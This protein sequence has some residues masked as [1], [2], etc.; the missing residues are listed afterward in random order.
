MAWLTEQLS[1]VRNRAKTPIPSRILSS[2]F[3]TVIDR[4]AAVCSTAPSGSVG[5]MSLPL[6]LH[7]SLL[8]HLTLSRRFFFELHV[9]QQLQ[10]RTMGNE[11]SPS[12]TENAVSN[13]QDCQA[14]AA[15]FLSTCEFGK[16]SVRMSGE[17]VLKSFSY[18]MR[19]AIG[20]SL[21]A[22]RS[23]LPAVI[24]LWKSCRLG[25][26]GHCGSCALNKWGWIFCLQQKGCC[27]YE[28][29]KPDGTTTCH[30]RDMMKTC[31]ND[32]E[33]INPPSDVFTLLGRE[34][35]MLNYV[36][37]AVVGDAN[38]SS[39]HDAAQLKRSHRKKSDDI[40]SILSAFPH[41]VRSGEGIFA[42]EEKEVCDYQLDGRNGIDMGGLDSS[43]GVY[44]DKL[45]SAGSSK[46][47]L[48]GLLRVEKMSVS[49]F[50]EDE[51]MHEVSCGESSI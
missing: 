48:D 46:E 2:P 40:D 23:E 50:A 31:G 18:A 43:T 35:F 15:A 26:I 11:I 38:S 19:L 13:L 45:S 32:D 51:R 5:S 17:N 42:S 36:G 27:C 3:D 21:L 10:K 33:S 44:S 39:P 37:G 22:V 16:L 30:C 47:D 4:L 8:P 24:D 1:Y 14:I 49:R 28:K 12:E 25:S 34:D 6:E 20:Q 7:H 29:K 9:C 41:L